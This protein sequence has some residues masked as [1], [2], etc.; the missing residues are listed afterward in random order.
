MKNWKPRKISNSFKVTAISFFF[1]QCGHFLEVEFDLTLRI[2]L[3]ETFYRPI[4]L[5]ILWCSKCFPI[6]FI[7]VPFQESIR[8]ASKQNAEINAFT[9]KWQWVKGSRC[10]VRTR[11]RFGSHRRNRHQSARKRRT[12]KQ[13]KQRFSRYIWFCGMRI[14]SSFN[15]T[16]FERW[17]RIGLWIQ[18]L[19]Y[20]F[21]TFL[22]NGV[23]F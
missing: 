12:S 21:F 19:Y 1:L 10:S 9:S 23:Q 11:G 3:T 20:Y 13:G 8:T 5:S 7:Q 22:K 16:N 6:Y 14:L 18:I 17:W 15:F 4:S 2:S